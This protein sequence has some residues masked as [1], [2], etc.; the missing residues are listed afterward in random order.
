MLTKHWS[1]QFVME[2]SGNPVQKRRK[3]RSQSEKVGRLKHIIELCHRID[4]KLDS[5]DR[6]VSRIETYRKHDLDWVR[7]DIEEICADEVDREIVRLV[8]EVGDSG[9]L[10]RVI[11]EK[12]AGFGVTR[13]HVARRIGRMNKRFRERVDEALF[14]QRGW[15]WALSKFA[16][17]A[18]G[19]SGKVE[20]D[21]TAEISQ[22]EEDAWQ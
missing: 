13:F 5:L 8:F 3:K 18:W 9:L 10:P 17:N 22:T 4:K 16:V 21:A 6:R 12:L 15:R 19:G 11:A 7:S 1:V 2:V 20:A 14:E